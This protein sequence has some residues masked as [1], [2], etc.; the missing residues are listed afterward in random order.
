MSADAAAVIIAAVITGAFLVLS[1]VWDRYFSDKDRRGRHDADLMNAE[2]NRVRLSDERQV[3]DYKRLEKQF[4][5]AETRHNMERA[6]DREVISRLTKRVSLLE[7]A[8]RAT[9]LPIPPTEDTDP[10]GIKRVS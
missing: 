3:A 9:N 10:D 2:D 8:L 4:K 1:R 5:E 6:A 7:N